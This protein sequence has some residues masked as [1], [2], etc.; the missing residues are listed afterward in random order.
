MCLAIVC[1]DEHGRTRAHAFV[2]VHTAHVSQPRYSSGLYVRVYIG[3]M[4]AYVYVYTRPSPCYEYLGQ[5]L[6]REW[7]FEPRFGVPTSIFLDFVNVPLFCF[8]AAKV[9]PRWLPHSMAFPFVQTLWFFCPLL[10]PFS[11]CCILFS[12]SF[13][14]FFL[15][16]FVFDCLFAFWVG[17]FVWRKR[18]R[19]RREGFSKNDSIFKRK[20]SPAESVRQVENIE[21]YQWNNS[22]EKDVQINYRRNTV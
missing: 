15:L 7:L 17:G 21:L 13:F 11:S 3:L 19:K 8:F 2:C 10:F 4:R 9:S 5:C 20:I 1:V 12:F 18:D 14:S 16:L 22:R 6:P